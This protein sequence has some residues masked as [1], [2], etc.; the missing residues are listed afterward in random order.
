MANG[1][2]K[3]RPTSHWRRAAAASVAIAIAGAVAIGDFIPSTEA[4]QRDLVKGPDLAALMKNW[5]YGNDPR[6]VDDY[7]LSFNGD[8]IKITGAWG[9]DEG[10]WHIE[11][12]Q[13]CFQLKRIGSGCAAV[14]RNPEGTRTNNDEYVLALGVGD[15]PFSVYTERPPALKDQ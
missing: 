5:W 8:E 11:A 9:W 15:F 14:Y 4:Q 1:R 6:Y 2:E 7:S 3:L 10:R 13:F 12:D